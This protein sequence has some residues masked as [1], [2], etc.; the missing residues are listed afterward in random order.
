MIGSLSPR[1]GRTKHP[2]LGVY[3]IR[4]TAGLRD[5]SDRLGL[6]GLG[7]ER[8]RTELPDAL[9]ASC[10][11]C[12]QRR[13]VIGARASAGLHVRIRLRVEMALCNSDPPLRLHVI[14]EWPLVAEAV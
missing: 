9:R 8:V 4:L 6:H 11:R 7:E 5:S 14:Y 3:V 1:C 13:L 12:S 10:V 2:Q